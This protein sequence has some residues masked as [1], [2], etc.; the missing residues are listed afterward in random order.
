MLEGVPQ[1]GIEIP[2]EVLIQTLMN[3]IMA[4]EAEIVHLQAG[5]EYLNAENERLQQMIPNDEE[6]KEEAS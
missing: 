3:K 4:K 5:A 1:Q 2:D 6:V